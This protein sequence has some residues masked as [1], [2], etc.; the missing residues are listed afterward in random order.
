MKYYIYLHSKGSLSSFPVQLFYI[1]SSMRSPFEIVGNVPFDLSVLQ[2]IF[3]DCKH[4]TDKARSLE[5]EGRIVRLKKGLYVASQQET[6][7]PVCRELVANHLY[8]PSYVSLQ[9]ALRFYGLIPE[10]VYMVC[11]VTTKQSRDFEN[12]IA[13]FHYQNCTPEYFPLGIRMEHRDN[14]S[15]LIASPEKALCDL[16]AFTPRLQF[17][18]ML[19]IGGWLEQDIRFDMDELATF[20]EEL[21]QQIAEHS[22]K[23]NS[24][25]TLISFL[26]HEKLI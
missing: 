7:I 18:S 4:I 24:I 25:I 8:G 10:Y 17:R 23:R 15:Y 5:S 6:E 14:Y 20:D 16:I 22:R 19:D 12:K 9:T 21:L 3:P 2:S 13:S 11:S 1:I 26:R